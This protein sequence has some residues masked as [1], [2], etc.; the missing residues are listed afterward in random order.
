METLVSFYEYITG[1]NPGG[2][3]LF[4]QISIFFLMTYN[5][6]PS[7]EVS[8]I[9]EIIFD[10]DYFRHNF[11]LNF[12]NKFEAPVNTIFVASENHKLR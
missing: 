1:S 9:L 12:S 4:F 7:N 3:L 8:S 6:K 5:G 10:M 2:R 11:L